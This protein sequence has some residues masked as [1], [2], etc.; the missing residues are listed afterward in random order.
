MIVDLPWILN[1][2]TIPQLKASL[3]CGA[4][5]NQLEDPE[6][7][8]RRLFDRGILYVPDF[9]VNR[10]GIVYCANEQYGY[11]TNDPLIN[12]HLSDDWE[13]SIYRMTQ[14]VLEKSKTQGKPAGV[15]AIELADELSFQLHPIHQARGRQI[16]QSLITN[17]WQKSI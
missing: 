4:A 16:I 10:M 12:Q 3:V 9:L 11:V 7:D 6:K 13:Y 2:E 5:N 14:K 1:Q 8:D 17:V 15:V